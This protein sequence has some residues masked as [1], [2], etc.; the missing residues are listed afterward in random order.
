MFANGYTYI[1]IAAILG[2]NERTIRRKSD[3]LFAK[4]D[5]RN[6]PHAVG[7]GF[8]EGFLNVQDVADPAIYAHLKVSPREKDIYTLLARG[9]SKESIM[10]QLSISDDTFRICRSGMCKKLNVASDAE[11]IAILKLHNKI[12]V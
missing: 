4:L 9:Y 1:D 7:I 12:Q 11:A 10:K 2:F 5:A 6:P 3:I 8:K